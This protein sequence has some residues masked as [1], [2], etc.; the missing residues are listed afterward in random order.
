MIWNLYP[1]LLDISF[2]NVQVDMHR[3]DRQNL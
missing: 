3:G 2:D 1:G